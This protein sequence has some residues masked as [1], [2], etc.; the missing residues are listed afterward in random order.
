[1]TTHEATATTGES[2]WLDTVSATSATASS[3]DATSASTTAASR[4]AVKRLTVEEQRMHTHDLDGNAATAKTR[5][6]R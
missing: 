6:L 1:M 3:P 2:S 5:H 4:R